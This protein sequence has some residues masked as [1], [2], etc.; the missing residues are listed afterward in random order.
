[1]H[2]IWKAIK[3]YEGLYEVSSLGRVK[4]LGK[5]GQNQFQG[6][7]RCK[8]LRI[9]RGGYYGINLHKNGE[10]SSRTVHRLVAETF[11]PNPDNKPQVNHKN[12]IKTDNRVEN[13]EFCTSKENINHAF[14]N[15]LSSQLGERNAGSK[16]NDKKV[17]VIKHI[18]KENWFGLSQ[19]TIGKI[20]DVNQQN[21]SNINKNK[22][23]SH[24]TI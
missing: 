14:E 22:R 3:G 19:G 6:N 10:A 17:R 1:M 16:L 7:E 2:E 12:G 23:W 15:G 18:L 4:S 8:T 11:I 24:I 21:V 9:K 5:G 13:L 20:F